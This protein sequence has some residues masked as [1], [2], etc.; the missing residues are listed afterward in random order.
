MREINKTSTKKKLK[1]K[2]TPFSRQTQKNHKPKT[3]PNH[4][5]KYADEQTTY[6]H[7][8]H[9][10]RAFTPKLSPDVKKSIIRPD[11]M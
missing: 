8:Y 9:E 2:S 10:N 1:F 11:E 4:A 3:R 6:E 7:V 5:T